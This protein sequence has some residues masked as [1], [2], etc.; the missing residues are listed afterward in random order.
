MSIFEAA[1]EGN[2]QIV[3][4]FI[5]NG[6]DVNAKDI[7]GRTALYLASYCGNLE[8]VKYLESKGAVK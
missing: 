7:L 8:I 1:W 6:A 3:K 2:L 5:E 4:E